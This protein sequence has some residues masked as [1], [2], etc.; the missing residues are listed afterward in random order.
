MPRSVLSS[1]LTVP[2]VLKQRTARLVTVKVQA[3]VIILTAVMM[4][5]FYFR[6]LSEFLDSVTV[7]QS[8]TI[9]GT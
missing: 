8:S 7:F 5:P 3:V 2:V 6:F 4:A 1:Y 9:A